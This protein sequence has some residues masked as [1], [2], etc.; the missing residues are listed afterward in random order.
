M[1]LLAEMDSG[2]P[3]YNITWALWL[4]GELEVSALQHPF[5]RR[6]PARWVAREPS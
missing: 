4:D 1:W 6:A 2:E 3:T 5:R